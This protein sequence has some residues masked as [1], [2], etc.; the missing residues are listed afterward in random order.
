[1]RDTEREAE[2]QAEGEA[3]SSWEDVALDPRTP[4]SRSKPKARC[5]TIQG[6]KNRVRRIRRHP[7]AQGKT[8]QKSREFPSPNTVAWSKKQVPVLLQV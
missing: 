6:F 7:I 3:G 1:M 8:G 4:G 5:P 2:T